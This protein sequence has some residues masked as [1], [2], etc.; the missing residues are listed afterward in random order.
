MNIRF[1]RLIKGAIGLTLF[2][3]LVVPLGRVAGVTVDLSQKWQYDGDWSDW[4]L[5]NVDYVG[6]NGGLR[7]KSSASGYETSGY[8]TKKFTADK[9][10]K[11][12]KAAIDQSATKT[13]QTFL[14][15]PIYQEGKVKQMTLDGTVVATYD[16]GKNPYRTAIGCDNDVWIANESSGDSSGIGGLSDSITHITS[17]GVAITRALGGSLV[18]PKSISVQCDLAA[19]KAYIWAGAATTLDVGKVVRFDAANFDSLAATENV[20]SKLSP[21]IITLTIP[22]AGILGSAFDKNYTN[23]YLA[24]LT[25][26]IVKITTSDYTF[27]AVATSCDGAPCHPLWVNITSDSR[28]NVW[29]ALAGTTVGVQSAEVGLINGDT[30]ALTEYAT[31][32]PYVSGISII[33]GG[34]DQ[35]DIIALSMA[36]TI[37]AEDSPSRMCYATASGLA[38]SGVDSY[39]CTEFNSSS[40]SQIGVTY[41]PTNDDILVI[42]PIP[43]RSHLNLVRFKKSETYTKPYYSGIDE[44]VYAYNNFTGPSFNPLA[45]DGKIEAQFSTDESKWYSLDELNSGKVPDSNDL[46]IKVMF[47]GQSTTSPILKSL[48]ISYQNE[49]DS[50]VHSDI[51]KKIFRVDKDETGVD[52]STF[53]STFDPGDTAVVRIAVTS[54]TNDLNNIQLT[55]YRP[56]ASG[57]NVASSAEK[58][59]LCGLSAADKTTAGTF[60]ASQEEVFSTWNNISIAKGETVYFCYKYVITSNAI[61]KNEL[62]QARAVLSKS[63]GSGAYAS[64]D[65][66]LLVRGSDYLASD[67]ASAKL[68]DPEN[69]VFPINDQLSPS[70]ATYSSGDMS[71]SAPFYVYKRGFGGKSRGGNLLSLPVSVKSASG[72]ELAFNQSYI[73]Y[74][75]AF[76]LFGNIFS[77]NSYAG[78]AMDFNSRFNSVTNKALDKTNKTNSE[79]AQYDYNFDKN[80]VIYW[81]S[82]NSIYKN[83][84]MQQSLEAYTK[85]PAPEVVCTESATD[86]GGSG[87]R[88]LNLQTKNCTNFKTSPTTDETWANGRVWY[89][90]VTASDIS[91]I[92]IGKSGVLTNIYGHGTIFV[93]FNNGRDDNNVIVNNL[94]FA[95]GAKMGLVV[96]GGRVSF[97]AEAQSFKGAIFNPGGKISFVKD[98]RPMKI[99][100]SLVS[101]EIEFNSRQKSFDETTQEYGIMIYNDAALLNQPLPG[102]EGLNS[103]TLGNQ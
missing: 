97:S 51:E 78:N 101:D 53:T 57:I 100:G 73:L 37:G 11:W 35:N 49:Y 32:D 10:A 9:T 86:L 64:S 80:S 50:S 98:G 6:S 72:Q 90:E 71:L 17:D 28:G 47:T 96:T 41:D 58:L 81:D 31:P 36:T 44:S 46:Y 65:N 43:S 92:D 30:G 24:S 15:L 67:S 91:T 63:D 59:S 79:S 26:N 84:Q 102:F 55:D 40:F 82:T 74:N 69:R 8:I 60:N 22:G 5:N 83:S 1:K 29:F 23:L 48:A 93:N 103:I 62:V 70:E 27:S 75:P 19:D 42:D 3:F 39:K 20:V 94:K 68:D 38:A 13:A 7:L 34:D 2:V 12:K 87:A 99:Y 45:S 95:D 21:R 77:G 61:T 14:W 76:Y 89:V 66:Y 25:G 4:I 54:K 52:K 16:T 85:I 18:G 33:P 56:K 88:L